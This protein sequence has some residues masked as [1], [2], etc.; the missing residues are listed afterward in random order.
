M[1]HLSTTPC[2]SVIM[3]CLN[4]GTH[5]RESLQSLMAQTM[6]DFEIIFYDNAS[7]DESASIAQSFG[8]K[9]RYFR[10]EETVP[11]GMAR[12]KAIRE[13]RG[14][15]IAFLDCDDVWEK[16]KLARQVLCM[17]QDPQIGLVTC[18]T[19]FYDGKKTFGRLF[20]ET[21][22]A[23]GY[24]FRELIERQ[25]I[26]M[27]SA[28]ARRS[29]LQSLHPGDAWQGPWFDESLNVCEEADV[30]YRIAHDWKLD[31]VDDCL[32][33]WRIHGRNTTFT[34]Y[35]AFARET[36][37]ILEKHKKLYPDYEKDYPDLVSLLTQRAS[38][39]KAVALWSKGKGRQAREEIASIRFHSLK[40]TLFWLCS[41]L[42]SSLFT[43]IAKLYFALPKKLRS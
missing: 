28:M 19:Y 5:L 27:S 21:K 41:F 26:S 15:F 1:D 7:T 11:L 13:A 25:W 9:V 36:L 43:L 20:E 40:Y 23:R 31:Y 2:V 33:Y 37:L 39:Q 6:Q 8:E 10:G 32:S 18:D 30:F 34:K 3:N 12:N 4:A 29:A 22:P 17:R 42:P 14:E 24:V 16:E 35:E 38:F